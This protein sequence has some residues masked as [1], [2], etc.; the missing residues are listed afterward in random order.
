MTSSKRILLATFG[1]LGDLHPYLAL[2]LG[3]KARGHQPIVAT[4]GAYE[5]TV[6]ALGL[7]FRAVRPD[8]PDPATTTAAMREVMDERRGTDVVLQQWVVPTLRDAAADLMTASADVD[9]IVSHLLTFAAPV[10]AEA[11]RL[12]WV[13]SILQPGSAFSIYDPPVVA[14][15][16]LLSRIPFLGPWF[17]RHFRRAATGYVDR[18]FAPLHELRADLGLPRLERS[19]VFDNPSPWLD[20]ALFSPLFGP[21]QPDWPPQTVITGFPFFDPPGSGDLPS[22]LADFFGEGPPPLV[23]TLGSSAVH[24]PGHFYEASVSAARRLGERALLLVGRGEGRPVGRLA[25]N[26]FAI[27]YV[28]H[29]AVFPRAAAI[30]HQG[31]IGTTAQ[32]LRAG[33]PMLVVPFAHDQPDNARRAVSLGVARTLPRRRYAAERVTRDLDAL[34]RDPRYTRRAAEIGVLIRAEDGVGRACDALEAVMDSRA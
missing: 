30:V 14:R 6:T 17:W 11:R 26:L 15:T 12:P 19:P 27:D 23:F 29:A 22:D 13:S 2:A 28:S 18:W 8:V 21:R 16:M 7:E 20:L 32:A 24:D 9:L 10:V 25:S 34:L 4:S 31:G 33:T 1:S 5:N 3:L